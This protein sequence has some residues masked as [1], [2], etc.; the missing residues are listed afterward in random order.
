MLNV[1]HALAFQHLD[2]LQ[3]SLIRFSSSIVSLPPPFCVFLP[4][5]ACTQSTHLF[6]FSFNL[7]CAHVFDK[8]K[9][10]FLPFIVKIPRKKDRNETFLASCREMASFHFFAFSSPVHTHTKS[11]DQNTL[12]CSSTFLAH[13]LPLPFSYYK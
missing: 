9:C 10:I 4:T 13:T 11:L 2:L 3:V 7:T 1:V 12:L 5:H 8:I 6:L